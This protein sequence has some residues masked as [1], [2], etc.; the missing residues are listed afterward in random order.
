MKNIVSG[1][2]GSVNI[3]GA[4]VRYAMVEVMEGEIGQ[5][6]KHL[7]TLGG[8]MVDGPSPGDR[9]LGIWTAENLTGGLPIK[10]ESLHTP[11]IT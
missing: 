3:V 10:E 1:S 7:H 2:I 6:F 4:T 9:L 8:V 5:D 11:A